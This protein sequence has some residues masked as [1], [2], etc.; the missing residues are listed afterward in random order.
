MKSKFILRI[1]AFHYFP[2]YLEKMIWHPKKKTLH[3][4]FLY[5]QEGWKDY[6]IINVKVFQEDTWMCYLFM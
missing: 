2:L 1:Q 5:L 3:K 6:I 4:G